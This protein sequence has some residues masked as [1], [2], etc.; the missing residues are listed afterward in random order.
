[1]ATNIVNSLFGID[2]AML[3]EARTKMDADRAFQFANLTPMEQ[4]QFALYSGG[5]ALGR[6]VPTLL[7]GE[8]PMMAKASMAKQ[9]ASQ[10]DITSPAGLRQYAQA[11]AQNNIPDLAE[12]ATDRA[13]KLEETVLR[14]EKTRSDITRTQQTIE[15]EDR[16]RE[17]L[18]KLPPNAS[19][20]QVIAVVSKYGSP[21][22]ILRVRQDSLNRKA[23]LAAKQA[24]AGAGI[25]PLTPAQK[26][27]DIAFAKDY[28]DFVS[29]GGIS[30]IQ[31]NLQ[32]LQTAIDIIEKG[33]NVSGKAV[34]LAD[35]TGSLSYLFPEAAQVKD[36]VGG[37]AQ[38]NL[39][40]VLGGQFAAKEGEQLLAR[41]YNT[42]QPTKDNLNRL[43]A[44]KKQIETAAAAKIQA[45]QEYEQ[46]GTLKNFR[47]AAVSGV[48]GNLGQPT[49][50]DPLGLFKGKK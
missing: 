28:N 14:T 7:G 6:A 48:I 24:T 35:A 26:A 43:K 31:K 39:R 47:P 21:D 42:A 11:L 5:A 38:S 15:K 18:A 36:L 29:G 23:A 19:D 40:Q 2:P 22:A 46:F 30:S 10:F 4:S 3:T 13:N 45:V 49:A 17:E 8:D 37:V 50:D 9:L 25:G 27:A 12:I 33:T 20:E 16:L 32:D 44:L 1:M 34:G 41:A